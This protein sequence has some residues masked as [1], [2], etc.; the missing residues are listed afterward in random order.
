MTYVSKQLR[1]LVTER[2]GRCC[3]YCLFSQDLGLLTF[4]MEHIVAEKHGGTTVAEN[5]ALACPY[6]NCAKGTDLGSL[7]PETG[8]LVPF[9]NPRTEI[10]KENFRIIQGIIVPLTAAGRVIEKT[11]GCILAPMHLK[12]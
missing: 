12:P 10:W 6:C 2:S 8:K 7:D 9:F 3:E 5:L 4:E 1:Q 11:R